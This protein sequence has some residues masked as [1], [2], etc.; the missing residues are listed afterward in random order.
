VAAGAGLTGG[1]ITGSGTISLA[2]TQLLPTIACTTNQI[3][4]WNGSAWACATA[5]VAATDVTVQI[6]GDAG[7]VA[8]NS[9]TNSQ[10][11]VPGAEVGD[12]LLGSFV[13][14]TPTPPG[15]VFQLLKVTAPAMATLRFCNPTNS[16]S[17]AF[18]NAGIRII[19]FR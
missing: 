9:C 3:V 4:K 2:T 12:V 16:P 14:P 6:S 15:L 8:S 7:A 17:V 1:P 11:D 18:S 10:L 5:S 13:G 19:T